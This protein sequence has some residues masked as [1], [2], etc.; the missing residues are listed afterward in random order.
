MWFLALDFTLFNCNNSSQRCISSQRMPSDR[1]TT[2]K[3]AKHFLHTKRKLH[4][5]R[6]QSIKMNKQSH[7]HTPNSRYHPIP[8][9]LQICLQL[10]C[11]S[12]GLAP[13]FR[14]GFYLEEET[15]GCGWNQKNMMIFLMFDGVWWLLLIFDDFCDCWWFLDDRCCIFDICQNRTHG[16]GESFLEASPTSHPWKLTLKRYFKLGKFGVGV[17]MMPGCLDKVHRCRCG[18][19][20]NNKSS[21]VTWKTFSTTVLQECLLKG[22]Q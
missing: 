2:N 10:R 11:S 14:W 15:V 13:D 4:K 3:I 7:T 17:L 8:I 9:H 1:K 19:G 5:N 6:I 16:F 18:C 20:W 12:L 21:G 22:L